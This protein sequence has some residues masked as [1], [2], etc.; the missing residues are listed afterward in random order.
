MGN[1]FRIQ[2]SNAL[3]DKY[4][5]NNKKVEQIKMKKIKDLA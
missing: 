5:T 1:I 4:D 3:N 2:L